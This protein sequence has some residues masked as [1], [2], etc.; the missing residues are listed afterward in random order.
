M[1]DWIFFRIGQ[2]EHDRE[3]MPWGGVYLAKD[4]PP[5]NL[6]ARYYFYQ[7]HLLLC[8]KRNNMFFHQ[9]CKGIKNVVLNR[10]TLS[11]LLNSRVAITFYNWLLDVEVSD[12]HK[13]VLVI[14]YSMFFLNIKGP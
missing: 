5:Y 14:D 7:K 1:I 4:P 9:I 2:G 10:E 11:F 13:Y 8:Q 12:Y 6:E 3:M